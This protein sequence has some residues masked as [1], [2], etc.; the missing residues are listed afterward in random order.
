MDKST[1]KLRRD[2]LKAI[3]LAMVSLGALSVFKT[4]KKQDYT[5]K[6]YRTLSKA[7][8]DKILKEEK[9]RAPKSLKPYPA[10]GGS[11]DVTG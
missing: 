9:F 1:N 2:F 11:E 6:Q 4:E 3:P 10:P 7:E 5:E 8:A